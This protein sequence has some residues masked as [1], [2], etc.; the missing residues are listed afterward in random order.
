MYNYTLERKCYEQLTQP[1]QGKLFILCILRGLVFLGNRS[2]QNNL[3]G[4]TK[5]TDH[6]KVVFYKLIFTFI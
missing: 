5:Q 1:H 4:A 6:R 2:H 3:S